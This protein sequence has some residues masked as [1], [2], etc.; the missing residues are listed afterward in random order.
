MSLQLTAVEAFGQEVDEPGTSR[1]QQTLILYTAGLNT[2]TAYDFGNLS[3]TFWT[4][5]LADSTYGT[6]AATAL[7]VLQTIIP[8]IKNYK[9]TYGPT[10]AAKTPSSG[11]VTTI[12]GSVAATGSPAVIT[13][14]G[15]LSTDKILA[16]TQVSPG[17][18]NLPL[19]GYSGQ[20]NNTL[21]GL[22]SGA[23][24]AGATVLIEVS[25]AGSGAVAAGGSVIGVQANNVPSLTFASGDAPTSAVIFIEW[26]L[27]PGK[28]VH[29]PIIP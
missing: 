10:L 24:G 3:G 22:Y 26:D 15:L 16:V 2:D 17:A 20:A 18:N 29:Y 19:L 25:R 14:T 4:Q 8:L 12:A 5:A 28:P 21:N 23:V 7:K 11:G 27:K 13:A 9:D 1:F 6:I